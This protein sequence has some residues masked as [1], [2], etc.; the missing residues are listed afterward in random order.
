MYMIYILHKKKYLNDKEKMKL[1]EYVIL[2][3]EVFFNILED[4]ENMD[5]ENEQEEFLLSEF[6]K[7]YKEEQ[8]YTT[9]KKKSTG[10]VAVTKVKSEGPT[11]YINEINNTNKDKYDPNLVSKNINIQS[12]NNQLFINVITSHVEPD[13]I[14]SPIGVQLKAKK[15]EMQEKMVTKE[16]NKNFNGGAIISDD[17]QKCDVGASPKITLLDKKKKN[18]VKYDRTIIDQALINIEKEKKNF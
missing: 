4:F 15:R 1:K 10:K 8:K 16:S 3:P 11:I 5:D 18:K 7:I 13:K 17:I 2:E 6:K 12:K 14:S 9:K